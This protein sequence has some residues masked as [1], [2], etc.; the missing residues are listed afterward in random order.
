M[1]RKA[2]PQRQRQHKPIHLIRTRR[3]QT[4]RNREGGLA[5]QTSQI[6]ELQSETLAQTLNS[7][8]AIPRPYPAVIRM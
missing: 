7:E 8:I 2:N 3:I 4:L 6:N 1:F 5:D